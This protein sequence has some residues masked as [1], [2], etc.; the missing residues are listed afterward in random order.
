MGAAWERDGRETCVPG[1]L[2]EPPAPY[3][4]RD[5][6][7]ADTGW[8]GEN[9]A[10]GGPHRKAATAGHFGLGK[11]GCQGLASGAACCL[12]N[13]TQTQ[14]VHTVARAE[15][16]GPGTALAQG[17]LVC[18]WGSGDPPE[19]W[20]SICPSPPECLSLPSGQRGRQPCRA[21]GTGGRGVERRSKSSPPPPGGLPGVQRILTST[22]RPSSLAWV[23]D[24][25]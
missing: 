8:G 14:A 5:R 9:R 23:L 19:G 2:W 18:L 12:G 1:V 21:P 3:R 11:G 16:W 15:S 17:R 13:H 6:Q 7:Q 22:P 24:L 4:S 25:T 10:R 20:L